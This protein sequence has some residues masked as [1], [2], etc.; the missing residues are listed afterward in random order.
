MEEQAPGLRA[1]AIEAERELI[2]MVIEMLRLH[3]AL[4]RAEQPALSMSAG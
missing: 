4:M 1:A 3:A 2:E